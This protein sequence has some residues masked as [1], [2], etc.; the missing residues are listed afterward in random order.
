[1]YSKEVGLDNIPEKAIDIH[2]I[3]TF[4]L[5]LLCNEDK[6]KRFK[7]VTDG[8]RFIVYFILFRYCRESV[9]DPKH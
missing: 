3:S 5:Y 2:D 4:W 1:M 7:Q 6:L 8:I 9:W